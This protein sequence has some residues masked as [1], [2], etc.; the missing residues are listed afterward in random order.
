MSIAAPCARRRKSNVTNAITL[1]RKSLVLALERS[2]SVVPTRCA[3]PILTCVRLEVFGGALTIQ[4]T[5]ID[6]ALTTQL[7]ADG[8][9][10]ACVVP[11]AEFIARLKAGRNETCTI[12]RTG[13]ALRINGGQVEHALQLRDPAD[14]PPVPGQLNGATIEVN[15][16]ELCKAL[17]VASVAVARDPSRYAINGILLESDKSDTRLVA[18]DGRRLVTVE[19]PATACKDTKVIF[20]QRFCQ[21]IEKF[22]AK[23][24]DRLVLGI[25]PAQNDKGET[26]PARLFVAGS[27]WL[28]STH[29]IEGSFPIYC[30]VIPK[31]HSRF[32]VDGAALL[33]ALN[34]VR[35]ACGDDSRMVCVDLSGRRIALSAGSAS[36]GNS[37]AR[38]TAKFL[39]G[40]DREI[41]TGFNPVFLHDAVKTLGTGMIVIDVDQNGLGTDGQVCSKPALLYRHE[42]PTVHWVIMPVNRGLEVTRANLGSKFPQYGEKAA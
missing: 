13:T 28:I 40:G 3:K 14:F 12:A 33:A 27:G 16:V 35:L 15:G 4:A 30:D 42:D 31:S 2:K 41:H 21:L 5:D 7:P 37:E 11:C 20:P 6:T 9:L 1:N 38:L 8:D 22:A 34:E 17:H 10:A 26:L 18:T 29:E 25:K 39:G 36:I 23:S 24:K 19:L 32:T